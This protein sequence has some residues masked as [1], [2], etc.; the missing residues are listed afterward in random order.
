MASPWS[1][2]ANSHFNHGGRADD[3]ERRA[4]MCREQEP[5][6][7]PAVHRDWRGVVMRPG[8]TRWPT[9]VV[10]SVLAHLAVAG[11]LFVVLRRASITPPPRPR[12]VE[13]LRIGVVSHA[14]DSVN[15]PPAPTRAG[16]VGA[17]PRQHAVETPA[18]AKVGRG[19]P[20]VPAAEESA[21]AE[22][23]VTP[24]EG[25]QGVS[26]PAPGAPVGAAADEDSR[27]DAADLTFTREL[28]ARLAEA[29]LRCYPTQARR[30][31]QQARV[32]VSFCIGG[33]GQPERIVITPSGIVSLDEAASRC[34]VLQAAPFPQPARGRCFSVPINFGTPRQ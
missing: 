7:S 12:T 3:A 11:G 19:D 13:V 5:A 15:R 20:F 16:R 10:I 8:A 31:R 17:A 1:A 29:A 6:P 28:H 27:A 2:P 23:L 9:A 14:A 30:F 22:S 25:S 4:A 24:V 34:V 32:P 26:P 18:V 33:D 21:T